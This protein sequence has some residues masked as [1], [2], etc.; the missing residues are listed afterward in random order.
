MS[1]SPNS[2]PAAAAA[3]SAS[4]GVS[5]PHARTAIGA[6]AWLALLVA[7][8][9]GSWWMFRAAAPLRSDVAPSVEPWTSQ[10]ITERRG[11]TKST[12]SGWAS[13]V[14]AR[15]PFYPPK[16][17][18]EPKPPIP[19]K[20]AGPAMAGVVANTVYFTD[21]KKIALGQ[22]E[23]GVE[24]LAINAPWSVRLR[25][26]G[27]EFDVTLVERQPIRFDQSPMLKDTL[28]K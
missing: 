14:T 28:F 18:E 8:G 1:N 19:P 10:Q 22:A 11:V 12:L 21:G 25:W 17:P 15:S 23:G 26:S 20:Y 5:S 6:L 3:I 27:G 16:P 2:A 7:L 4:G 13:A 9:L 24:V